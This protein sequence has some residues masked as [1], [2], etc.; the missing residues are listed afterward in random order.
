M[1]GYS[2]FVCGPC[3]ARVNWELEG[4]HRPGCRHATEPAVEPAAASVEIESVANES[5]AKPK[6]SVRTEVLTVAN[7]SL[8]PAADDFDSWFRSLL[9][10]PEGDDEA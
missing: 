3:G 10:M 7:D 6:T 5:V 8:L 2:G 9:T 1:T 4:D